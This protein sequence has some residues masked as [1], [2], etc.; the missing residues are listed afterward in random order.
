MAEDL[1]LKISCRCIPVKEGLIY[2]MGSCRSKF[3][4]VW[5]QVRSVGFMDYQFGFYSDS[6]GNAVALTIENYE[7]GNICFWDPDFSE[8]DDSELSFD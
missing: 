1:V 4:D 7:S 6:L 2:V 5:T 8:V 3:Y